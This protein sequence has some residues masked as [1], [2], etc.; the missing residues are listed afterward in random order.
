MK[1]SVITAT[2]NSAKTLRDTIESVLKQTFTDYEYVVIDGGSTDE[3]L[4]IV[5]E[6]EPAFGGRL[7]CYSEPDDGIYDA[8]NKGIQLAHGEVVGLLNSDDFYSSDDILET[9]AVAFEQN[10]IDAVYADVHYVHCENTNKQIRNYSSKPFKRR[11]MRFGFMPAHP[12]FYCKK[13]VYE[14]YGGFDTSYKVAADFEHL[15]RVIYKNRIRTKYIEKDFVTMRTG[16]ASN[17]SLKS[18]MQ[19]MQDH[20]VALKK[21]GVYSNRFLLSLRYIYKIYT[22]A[23][24]KLK[25]K[26]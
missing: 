17:V 2:Y 10:D 18:R 4:D 6:Y 26:D 5:R 8:M 1:I 22:L 14:K 12:S 3:T 24:Q 21:N 20:L 9:I 23:K 16:G 19:I 25:I 11:W 13:D 15:L 7:K